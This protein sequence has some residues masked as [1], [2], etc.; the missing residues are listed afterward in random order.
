MPHAIPSINLLRL[1]TNLL[2]DQLSLI[3]ARFGP[4]H[5]MAPAA[6]FTMAIILGLYVRSS[7]REAR[8]EA[9]VERERKLEE[10]RERQY[11]FPNPRTR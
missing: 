1:S 11:N 7:I 10:L 2:D 8:W 9:Q 5:F 4:G 3:M 6:A